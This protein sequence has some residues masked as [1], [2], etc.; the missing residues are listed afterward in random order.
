MASRWRLALWVWLVAGVTAFAHDAVTGGGLAGMLLYR[1][2]TA[3]GTVEPIITYIG[4]AVPLFAVPAFML[5]PRSRK[6]I[7]EAP[8]TR[9]QRRLQ[10][11]ISG[12]VAGVLGLLAI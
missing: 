7:A 12:A 3:Y 9:A 1:E 2:L 4:I 8:A 11:L 6:R 5:L 10:L